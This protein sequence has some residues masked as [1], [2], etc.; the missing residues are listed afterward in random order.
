[1]IMLNLSD[2]FQWRIQTISRGGAVNTR[3]LKN[4]LFPFYCKS[5][6]ICYKFWHTVYWVQLQHNG[7]WLVH[8][9]TYCCHTTLGNL[10]ICCF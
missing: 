9:P 10:L 8:P 6:A 5:G 4:H 2:L 3:W 7:Y 1:M